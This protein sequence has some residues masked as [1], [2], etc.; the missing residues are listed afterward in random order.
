HRAT[1]PGY[2]WLAYSWTNYVYAC[3]KCNTWKANSFPLAGQREPM[4][5]GIE[6]R[7]DALLL[8]PF[9]D[10]PTG[11][12]SFDEIGQI[13]PQ[14]EKGRITIDR[15][16]LD[17]ETLRRERARVAAKMLQHYEDFADGLL[18]PEIANRYLLGFCRDA[19]PYAAMARCLV[20]EWLGFEVSEVAELARAGI[21]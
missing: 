13:R 18:P 17:R 15:C 14:T 1:K 4:D 8:N 11:H 5:P 9:L 7:E 10:D 21:D 12:L 2:W 3:K 6:D 16:G 19:E 20:A